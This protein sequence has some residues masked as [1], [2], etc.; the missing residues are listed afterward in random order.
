MIPPRT[1]VSPP[2]SSLLSTVL[3]ESSPECPPAKDPDSLFPQHPEYDGGRLFSG[4]LPSIL[5]V[6]VIGVDRIQTILTANP[7]ALR[8]AAKSRH[9]AGPAGENTRK[10]DRP[11]PEASETE[12]PAGMIGKMAFDFF[13]DRLTGR[14]SLCIYSRHPCSVRDLCLWGGR[15]YAI[16]IPL[17]GPS[18]LA[19]GV[20]LLPSEIS[21]IPEISDPLPE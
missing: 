11:K 14:I 9:A 5:P 4:E 1:G 20:M 15:F 2:A 12:A 16:C 18:A 8:L 19:A 3:K 17:N 7:A 21:G 10:E 6:P 13:P